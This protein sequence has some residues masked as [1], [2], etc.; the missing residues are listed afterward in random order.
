MQVDNV[1]R[2]KQPALNYL[3]W[4]FGKNFEFEFSDLRMDFSDLDFRFEALPVTNIFEVERI[5]CL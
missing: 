3:R 5:E 1:D 4:F 2:I